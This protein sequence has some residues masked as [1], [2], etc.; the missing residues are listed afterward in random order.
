MQ[1]QL[2]AALCGPSFQRIVLGMASPLQRSGA[3]HLRLTGSCKRG[4]T[5]VVSLPPPPPHRGPQHMHRC[6]AG[7]VRLVILTHL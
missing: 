6:K 3:L 5:F 2:P 1:R 4:L 7:R